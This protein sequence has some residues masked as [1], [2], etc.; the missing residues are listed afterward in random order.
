MLG[1]SVARG[2]H[3]F[4]SKGHDLAIIFLYS[5]NL[6]FSVNANDG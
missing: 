6:V 5:P 4:K 2:G 3:N 1:R